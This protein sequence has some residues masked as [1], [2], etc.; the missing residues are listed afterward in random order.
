MFALRALRVVRRQRLKQRERSVD[1][2][3]EPIADE[4]LEHLRDFP[5]AF[6][7]LITQCR[8]RDHDTAANDLQ[9]LMQ[10]LE[11]V[12]NSAVVFFAHRPALRPF[13]RAS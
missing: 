11:T 5:I 13:T 10:Q 2:G 4:V 12:A 6:G 9:I 3:G 1:L 8:S 7:V